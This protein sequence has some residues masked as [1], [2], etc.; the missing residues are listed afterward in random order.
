M[1]TLIVTLTD[2]STDTFTIDRDSGSLGMQPRCFSLGPNVL[3]VQQGEAATSF[4]LA[5]IRK[6]EVR[7]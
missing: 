7:P 5:S 2:G 1:P 3:H 6:W 4:P